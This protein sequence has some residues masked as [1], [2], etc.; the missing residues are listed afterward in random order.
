VAQG[1]H[2]RLPSCLR[3]LGWPS[4]GHELLKERLALYLVHIHLV[5]G[6][7]LV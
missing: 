1:L 3:S 6:L 4:L 5:Q 2:N 7:V